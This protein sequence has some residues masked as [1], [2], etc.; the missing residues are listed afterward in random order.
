MRHAHTTALLALVLLA[1]AC[2]GAPADG[3]ASNSVAATPLAPF[4]LQFVGTYSASAPAPGALAALTL[5]RDGTFEA[6]IEGGGAPVEGTFQAPEARALPLTLES[7][8]TDGWTA[9]LSSYDGKLQT[10]HDG[11]HATLRA[12]TPVGPQE[13]T[14]ESTGGTWDDDDADPAT[15]LYCTCPPDFA[16]VPSA[17]GCVN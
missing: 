4:A 5:H 1:S 8:G 2:S 3:T 17:G 9:T 12:R 7:T 14:C 15:G 13:S 6:V 16:Y 10:L 11:V